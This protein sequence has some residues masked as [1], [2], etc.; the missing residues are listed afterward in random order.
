VTRE[1]KGN[2][3][4]LEKYVLSGCIQT[5]EPVRTGE[6]VLTIHTG[7][8]VTVEQRVAAARPRLLR[9]VQLNG[10]SPDAVEDVVQETLLEAWY[11]LPYLREPD[12]VDAWLDGICRNMCRRWWRTTHTAQLRHEYLSFQDHDDA[13]DERR[14]VEDIAD[15]LAL[16]PFE[17]LN[18]QDLEALLD[19]ALGH[20][21]PAARE[22][23]ELSYLAELPQR[24]VAMRL[25]VTIGALEE[26]L[27]R[28]RHRLQQVLNGALRADAESL[29]VAVNPEQAFGWRETR[30]WCMF[31]GRHRLR[32][33]FESL[34]DGHIDLRLRCP[35]CSRDEKSDIANSGGF[36]PL[37]GLYSF[38]PALHRV[39]QAMQPYYA[40]ALIQGWQYCQ[41]CGAVVQAQIIGPNERGTAP[42]R[43]SYWP[44]LLLVLA[45]SSCGHLNST[46]LSMIIR[47]VHP[48]ALRF[49]E[50]HPRWISEPEI[51][52]EYDGQPA[53]YLQLTDIT[54][55]ARL[56]MFVHGHSWQVIATLQ[57]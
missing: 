39:M 23:V 36:I 54:S 35:S 42:P 4:M 47:T 52:G 16:D 37:D 57:E 10:V 6:S 43:L 8:I 15:P 49:M 24:E 26:R 29:G 32:G 27:R 12:R 19:R 1:E 40:Q 45:C 30:E 5:Q 22:A 44:G 25:G 2:D 55:A 3:I 7:F 20:L 33:V 48:V 14:K 28:A 51:L 13:G 11:H 21:S 50:Q 56:T 9:L 41:Q 34:P 46:C 53:I 31:C 38:R 17:E 18:H